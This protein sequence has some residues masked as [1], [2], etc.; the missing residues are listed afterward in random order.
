MGPKPVDQSAKSSIKTRSTDTPGKVGSGSPASNADKVKQL[1]LVQESDGAVGVTPPTPPPVQTP[2]GDI[3]IRVMLQKMDSKLEKRFQELEDKF[4]GMFDNLKDEIKGLRAEVA[5]SKTQFAKLESKVQSIEDAAEFNSNMCKERTEK[6]TA[7][8]NKVKAE[9]EDKVKDLENKLLLQEKQDRKYNLLFYGITEELN[10]N[11]EN[12]LKSLFVDDLQLDYERVNN[13][14][15]V[16]YHRIPSKSPGPKPIILRFCQYQ[17]RDLVLSN[18]YK[19]AGS[20]RRIIPDWPVIMKNERGRLAKVA[21]K[22]RMEEKLKTRIKDKGLEVYLEVRK[23][24]KSEWL[25]R[26]V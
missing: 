22:I 5:E 21:Y 6:Q 12:K 24:D 26:D 3:S 17:D 19:L 15:F 2:E 10:E 14:Y 7:L 8:L 20:K 23:D 9:L 25:R 16:H 4:I 11:I 18:A 13:M 1:K